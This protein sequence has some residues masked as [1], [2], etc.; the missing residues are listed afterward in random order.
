M[1]LIEQLKAIL[2][3]LQNIS[4]LL[5]DEKKGIKVLLRDI[6]CSI[7]EDEEES[8]ELDKEENMSE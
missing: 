7:Q 6:E 8:E 4:R 1:E 2:S 5:N 3:S